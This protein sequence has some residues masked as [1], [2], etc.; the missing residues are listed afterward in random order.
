[1]I[2]VERVCEQCG[3]LAMMEV[4]GQSSTRRFCDVCRRHRAVQATIRSRK[5]KKP[6]VGVRTEIRR[7]KFTYSA[8]GALTGMEVLT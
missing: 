1:M 7:V 8:N 3:Q 6:R 5:R 4:K 2:V